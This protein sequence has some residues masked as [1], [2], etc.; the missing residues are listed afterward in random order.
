MRASTA[1]TSLRTPSR[2][3]A[4]SGSRLCSAP[5][6]ARRRS[7]RTP[8]RSLPRSGAGSRAT[9]RS[10]SPGSVGSTRT[11]WTGS[12]T[13]SL[14]D[15]ANVPSLLSLPYLGFCAPD[16]P[17][18]R[19]DARLAARARQPE[20]QLGPGVVGRR[21]HAREARL[22]LAARD[23]D[24]G[25]DRDR[26]PRAGGGSPSRRG[27]GDR[28]PALPRVGRSGRSPPIQ[29]PLVLVGGHALRG[30]R[31]RDGRDP[32]P[33][34]GMSGRSGA[35]GIASPIRRGRVGDEG[36][37]RVPRREPTTAARPPGICEVAPGG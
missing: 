20:S 12:A 28:R 35:A 10:A 26:R 36:S 18:Y 25:P 6:S 27:D 19:V 15:D 30:A 22:G 23:R 37:P 5:R 17:L 9:A 34:P 11:R 32:A 31:A 16:E 21:Q 3:S 14:L 7:R 8:P 29:A 24:G 13:C 2:P 1:T 33:R 4:S